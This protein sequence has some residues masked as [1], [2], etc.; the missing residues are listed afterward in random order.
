MQKW[1]LLPVSD[2]GWV[3]TKKEKIDCRKLTGG[4]LA[5]I[6][7]VNQS[8]RF[9]VTIGFGGVEL[10]LAPGAAFPINAPTGGYLVSQYDISFT[11][12]AGAAAAIRNLKVLTQKYVEQ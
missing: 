8:S 5:S 11:L 3:Q 2:G 6:M 1:E 9:N 7:F 12:I 10:V 4:K